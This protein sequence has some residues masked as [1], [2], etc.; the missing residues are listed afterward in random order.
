MPFRYFTNY[1]VPPNCVHAIKQLTKVEDG[2]KIN[3][4][5]CGLETKP[6]DMP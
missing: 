3:C 5:I 2:Y 6:L 1:V 4:V